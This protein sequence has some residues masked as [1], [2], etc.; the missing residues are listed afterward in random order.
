MSWPS[1]IGPPD[2]D[3]LSAFAICAAMFQNSN[4]LPIALIQSLVMEVPG[5]KWGVHDTKDQM[6]GRALTYL[7][8]YSTLGMMLRWSW[9]VKILSQADEEAP[10]VESVLPEQTYRDEPASTTTAG[11]DAA[12]AQVASPEALETHPGARETDPF[13]STAENL[14]RDQADENRN[15]TRDMSVAKQTIREGSQ[16]E[17]DS[18]RAPASALSAHSMRHPGLAE[19]ERSNSSSRQGRRTSVPSVPGPK[20]RRDSSRASFQGRRKPTRQE[21]GMHFLGLPDFPKRE[22]IMLAEDSSD[23]ED[24]EDEVDEEWVCPLFHCIAVGSAVLMLSGLL[25][26]IWVAETPCRASQVVHAE[27]QGT[28][29]PCSEKHQR[30]PHR[31]HVRGIAVHLHRLGPAPSAD[32]QPVG[33]A[34]A[35]HQVRRFLL[36]LVTLVTRAIEWR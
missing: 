4:S 22:R 21:S 7:V 29:H 10:E 12:R 18:W 33:P 14:A 9:G 26:R 2:V 27:N 32:A 5:L 19:R 1:V 28:H 36:Q 6:L 34:R 8:L 31:P 17:S 23:E 30:L 25:D 15:P 3:G 24:D 20:V 16:V 13:F 35:S 11:A